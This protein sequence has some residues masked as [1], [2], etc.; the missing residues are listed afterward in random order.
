MKCL[1]SFININIHFQMLYWKLQSCLNI[2][3]NF[4]IETYKHC[5]WEKLKVS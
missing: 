3:E 1:I 5:C 2:I 4:I